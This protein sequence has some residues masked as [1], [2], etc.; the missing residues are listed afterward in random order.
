MVLGAVLLISGVL[1]MFSPG[2]GS[3]GDPT[4]GFLEG[5]RSFDDVSRRMRDDFDS[6][7]RSSFGGFGMVAAGMFCLAGGGVMTKFGYMGRVARY[8]AQEIAPVATDTVGFVVD[9]TKDEM[10]TAAR[11]ITQGI[12]DGL[13]RPHA[14]GAG[15]QPAQGEQPAGSEHAPGGEHAAAICPRC[16]APAEEGSKFCSQC[17]SQIEAACPHCGHDVLAGARFCAHCGKALT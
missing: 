6:R 15:E 12:A 10:Q 13:G 11:A 8:V 5:R 4:D 14:A 16:G 1:T 9:E 17:G 2:F 3:R 7:A